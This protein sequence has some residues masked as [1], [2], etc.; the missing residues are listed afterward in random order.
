[1]LRAP[2]LALLLTGTALFPAAAQS[3]GDMRSTIPNLEGAEPSNVPENLKDPKAADIDISTRVVDFKSELDR[4]REQ[5]Q[6]IE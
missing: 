2:C 3:S 4:I 5:V 6:N 1:M